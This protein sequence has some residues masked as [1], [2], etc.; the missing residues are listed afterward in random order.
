[1]ATKKTRSLKTYQVDFIKDELSSIGLKKN[2][3]SV[4]NGVSMEVNCICDIF[5]QDQPIKIYL[6]DGCRF[7]YFISGKVRRV[8]F[9]GVIWESQNDYSSVPYISQIMY[10]GQKK[11]LIASEKKGEI[12]GVGKI[13]LTTEIYPIS[14]F[15]NNVFFTAKNNVVYFTNPLDS[16]VSDTNLNTENYFQVEDGLGKICTLHSFGDT[17]YVVCANGIATLKVSGNQNDYILK[18]LR[19]DY[20]SVVTNSACGGNGNVCFITEGNVFCSFDGSNIKRIQLIDPDEG[21]ALQSNSVVWKGY[22]IVTIGVGFD[23]DLK[24]YCINV[25][26]GEICTLE[27]LLAI[28][29]QGGLGLHY[30]T[31][32]IMQFS[33][34]AKDTNVDCNY[35]SKDLDMGTSSRKRFLGVEGYSEGQTTL[36][37]H[38]EFGTKKIYL[39][40]WTVASLNDVS[41]KIS[42]SFSVHN[43][44]LPV[45][46]IKFK[47]E[48]QEN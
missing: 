3:T 23:F 6:V 31:F 46:N 32:E 17:L 10:K 18:R 22:Y 44:L 15:C 26:T 45:K 8:G 11:I 1:M 34:P 13:T 37:L 30:G 33:R 43:T 29:E 38:G 14:T 16:L 19:T 2:K 21:M 48:I 35:Y 42:F 39:N 9:D 20:I 12:Y 24:T 28:S 25:I 7:V 41:D 5:Y 27:P 36:T 4:S 47:Y 40:K